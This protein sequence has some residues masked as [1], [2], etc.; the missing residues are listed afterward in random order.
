MRNS[1]VILFSILLTITSCSISTD[2]YDV[3]SADSLVVYNYNTKMSQSGVFIAENGTVS[4]GNPSVSAADIAIADIYTNSIALISPSVDTL[5]FFGKKETG[6]YDIGTYAYRTAPSEGYFDYELPNNEHY[7][8]IMTETGMYARM[9]ILEYCTDSI[10]FNI[11]VS[12]DSTR[13]NE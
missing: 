4:I 1:I 12:L 2:L 9:F 11:Q 6:L 10:L 13:F 3:V 7:Y 8:F 5:R